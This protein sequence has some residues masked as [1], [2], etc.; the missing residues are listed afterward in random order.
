[1]SRIH[2]FPI[3]QVWKDVLSIL[4]QYSAELLYGGGFIMIK[5]TKQKTN[6]LQLNQPSIKLCCNPTRRNIDYERE[7]KIKK[8]NPPQKNGR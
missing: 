4:K 2:F 8:I 6:W 7:K 1:M 3:E 5:K